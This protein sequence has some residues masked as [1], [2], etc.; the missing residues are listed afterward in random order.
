MAFELPPAVYSPQL[1][2]SVLHEIE[3]Y[4]D[5]YRNSRI[6][7]RVGAATATAPEPSRSAETV[8]VIESWL[9]DR[10]PTVEAVEE[11]MVQLRGLEL[12]TAHVTMAALPNREQRAQL[13]DWFRR[14]AGNTVLVAF[15]ADRSLGGGVVVRTPNR[16]FDSSWR[17]RLIDGRSKL[18]EIIKRV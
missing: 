6:Q 8:L 10:D 5:W 2:E 16:T 17:Q 4:V 9:A 18:A 7:Q 12:P 3:Q 11:L 14:T 15:V 1:L 13:V